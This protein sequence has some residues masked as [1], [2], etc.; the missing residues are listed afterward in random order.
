ML[1]AHAEL[2]A[3]YATAA[4]WLPPEAATTPA[5]GTS[6]VSRL[7]NAPRALNEP[8]CCSSSSLKLEP[9]KARPKSAART[10]ITGVRRTCGRI[11]RST[12][13]IASRSRS[14]ALL[15][16]HLANWQYLCEDSAA[17][18]RALANERRLQILEW[19][20]QPRDALSAP[21]RR[22]PGR[23]TE[24][25]RRCIA[26]KLGVSQ[27]AAQRAHANPGRRRPGARQ[28]HQAVDLLQARRARDPPGEESP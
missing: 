17:A 27:P 11:R 22:R 5:A 6:R 4:P 7:A 25:A 20:K 10:S 1:R 26:E 14:I 21:G 24:S 15:Y 18:L 23:A 12:S 3:A 8:A 28:A 9:A 13:A 2:L 16:S 19:L